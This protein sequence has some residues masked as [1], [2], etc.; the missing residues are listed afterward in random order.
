MPVNFTDSHEMRF[1]EKFKHYHVRPL[2]ARALYLDFAALLE[3]EKPQT[4]LIKKNTFLVDRD[5]ALE[6]PRMS[7]NFD[8]ESFDE[9]VQN[10][11]NESEDSLFDWSLCNFFKRYPRINT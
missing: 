1:K 8:G 6:D 2:H 4:I 5:I 7:E 3:S 9:F 11:L 10:R